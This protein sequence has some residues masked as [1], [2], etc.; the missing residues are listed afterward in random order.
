MGKSSINGPFSMAMLNNQR[1]VNCG[2]KKNLI[3]S[4]RHRKPVS[5]LFDKRCGSPFGDGMGSSWCGK[6]GPYTGRFLSK[7]RSSGKAR[8]NGRLLGLKGRPWAAMVLKPLLQWCKTCG[9][10]NLHKFADDVAC[11]NIWSS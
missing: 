8:S 1:V 5:S 2:K 4:G 3:G 6:K 7:V 11:K 9:L 10:R